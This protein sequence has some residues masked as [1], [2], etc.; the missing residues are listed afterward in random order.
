MSARSKP[1]EVNTSAIITNDIAIATMPS[2]GVSRHQDQGADEAQALV[3]NLNSTIHA[4]PRNI[5]EWLGS[6]KSGWLQNAGGIQT[7]LWVVTRSFF[8]AHQSNRS[9]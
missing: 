3:E 6:W 8:P 2:A 4:A 7:A 1:N 9:E 5:L